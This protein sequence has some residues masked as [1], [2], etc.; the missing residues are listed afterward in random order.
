MCCYFESTRL[1][2]Y[3]QLK[4]KVIGSPSSPPSPTPPTKTSRKRVSG[5]F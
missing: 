5:S 4:Y 1:V 3:V 2:I